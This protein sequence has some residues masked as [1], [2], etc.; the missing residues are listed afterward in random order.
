ML[1]VAAKNMK[2]ECGSQNKCSSR[3]SL[4]FEVC[5]IR[6]PDQDLN[7]KSQCYRFVD[8]AGNEV[9]TDKLD[10]SRAAINLACS[11]LALA[12]KKAVDPVSFYFR[13]LQYFVKISV[14]LSTKL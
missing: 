1:K 14:C 12:M 9:A 11:G 10:K 5:I 6:Q 7:V 3:G 8:V 2:L 13:A 4:F